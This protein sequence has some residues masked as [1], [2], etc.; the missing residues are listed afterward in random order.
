MFKSIGLGICCLTLSISG[1]TRATAI[2]VDCGKYGDDKCVKID[3]GC[4]PVVK[5]LD[6]KLDIG[7]KDIC[8][9]D[10]KDCDKDVNKDC[11]DFKPCLPVV[12]VLCDNKDGNK[13]G[14]DTCQLEWIDN[15]D[16]SLCDLGGPVCTDGNHG[17]NDCNLVTDG[18][19]FNP[20]G[21]G[22][23]GGCVPCPPCPPSGNPCAAVPAPASAGFGGLGVL[24]MMVICRM[25]SR[26]SIIC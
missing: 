16:H 12:P 24:G 25:R 7:I 22:D 15:C 20:C 8:K 26:R 14:K 21:N 6:F 5:C 13:G 4:K 2:N 10:L 9:L 23:H 3:T 17:H 18:C 1:V 19:G 11:H